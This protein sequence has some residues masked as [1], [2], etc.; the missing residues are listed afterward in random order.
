MSVNVNTCRQSPHGDQG[1]P[2]Y[3]SFQKI[4]DDPSDK[5]TTQTKMN[6]LNRCWSSASIRV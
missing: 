5:N 6:C 2:I 1:E 3:L 4:T